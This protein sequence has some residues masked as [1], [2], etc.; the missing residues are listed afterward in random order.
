MASGP[1]PASRSRL[2]A[3]PSV[4]GSAASPSLRLAPPPCLHGGVLLDD[5]QELKD[6]GAELREL[7]VGDA[8]RAA[9]GPGRQHGGEIAF[10]DLRQ[11]LAQALK[12]AVE[13]VVDLAAAGRLRASRHTSMMPSFW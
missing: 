9:G 7:M 4:P 3:H 6:D 10:A 8:R 5:V 12:Q 1:M 2:N 11:H 13:V